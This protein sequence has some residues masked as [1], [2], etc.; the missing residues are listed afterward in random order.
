M[1]WQEICV[2]LLIFQAIKKLVANTNLQDTPVMISYWQLH[3]IY[4]YQVGSTENQI[5]IQSHT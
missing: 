2:Y 1:F 5:C 4:H 3:N